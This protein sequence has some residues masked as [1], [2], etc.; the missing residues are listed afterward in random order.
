MPKPV[1][2][3][4]RIHRFAVLRGLQDAI[5]AVAVSPDGSF[6]LTVSED[7]T[8]RLWDA[9]SFELLKVINAGAGRV[10]GGAFSSYG[11]RLVTVSR[12]SIARIWDTQTGG[13]IH[14]LFGHE[15]GVVG[16]AFSPDD[17]LVAT[18]GDDCTRVIVSFANFFRLYDKV[19]HGSKSSPTGKCELSEK[20]F[21]FSTTSAGNMRN[22]LAL[23]WYRGKY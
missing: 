10:L 15:G 22:S 12:D 9:S 21:S 5:E 8:A 18:V 20:C 14:E 6:I 16:A 3:P 11:S 19:I 7:G 23:N 17:T 2:R 13:L 1:G 4:R